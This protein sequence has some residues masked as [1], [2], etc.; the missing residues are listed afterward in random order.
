MRLRHDEN[1]YRDGMAWYVE[2]LIP[3]RYRGACGTRPHDDE[4][5]WFRLGAYGSKA[6]AQDAIVKARG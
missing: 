3:G 5:H 6:A 1:M 2:L 4:R